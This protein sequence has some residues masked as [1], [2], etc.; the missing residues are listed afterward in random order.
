MSGSIP[1]IKPAELLPL[2]SCLLRGVDDGGEVVVTPHDK[3]QHQPEDELS[4]GWVGSTVDDIDHQHGEDDAVV[5]RWHVVVD[6]ADSG[7]EDEG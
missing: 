2:Q 3:K 1:G 4:Q 6:E 5:E 7:D